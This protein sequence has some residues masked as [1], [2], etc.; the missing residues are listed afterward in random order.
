MPFQTT[1]DE[2]PYGLVTGDSGRSFYRRMMDP[3]R[4]SN[5]FH[6]EGLE[7]TVIL[8]CS[9]SQ[10]GGR[11]EQAFKGGA[12][13]AHL[14]VAVK[15][16]L[17]IHEVIQHNCLAVSSLRLPYCHGSR[18]SLEGPSLWNFLASLQMMTTLR[19]RTEPSWE[20]EA[21][22]AGRPSPRA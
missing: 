22:P 8:L 5:P 14:R 10:D 1:N 3:R 13:R 19:L 16:K 17:I 4:D 18:Q 21:A 7:D 12:H 6:G 9:T 2:F 20:V 11:T 15:R